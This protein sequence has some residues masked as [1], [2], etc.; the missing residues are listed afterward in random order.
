MNPKICMMRNI[1]LKYYHDLAPLLLVVPAT[2][3]QHGSE[4]AH[5]RSAAPAS[6]PAL[7]LHSTVCNTHVN[8]LFTVYLLWGGLKI[9]NVI[10]CKS[11]PHPQ[12]A[13]P[14]TC[15]HIIFQKYK[16]NCR[17]TYLYVF[18]WYFLSRIMWGALD[19]MALRRTFP[20]LCSFS[21]GI[22]RTQGHRL[23][24]L[25][26]VHLN[27]WLTRL[28]FYCKIG[29][30]RIHHL[31]VNLVGQALSGVCWQEEVWEPLFIQDCGPIAIWLK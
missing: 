15:K 4:W 22:C 12:K 10:F 7:C 9:L 29:C 19:R 21:E 26:L 24:W 16:Q 25:H 13:S 23:R 6:P 20:A 28:R 14:S 2:S 18:R 11:T 3:R 27:L 17:P 5:R 1:R 30:D 8:T 31:I